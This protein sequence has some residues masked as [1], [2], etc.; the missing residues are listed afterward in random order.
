MVRCCFFQRIDGAS[1]ACRS[2]K[3]RIDLE[4]NVCRLSDSK[5]RVLLHPDLHVS[6]AF[7]GNLCLQKRRS[8]LRLYQVLY[9]QEE[10]LQHLT[11]T[12]DGS[13]KSRFRCFCL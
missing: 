6:F 13:G 5:L 3:A 1:I 8:V 12:H 11:G 7:F 9:E 10:I 4:C 2:P